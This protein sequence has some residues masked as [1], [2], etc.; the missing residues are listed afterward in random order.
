MTKQR[1]KVQVKKST[2]KII[3]APCYKST[4]PH[5]SHPPNICNNNTMDIKFLVQGRQSD[6]CGSVRNDDIFNLH[7]GSGADPSISIPCLLQ[8]TSHIYSFHPPKQLTRKKNPDMRFNSQQIVSYCLGLCT[9][10]AGLRQV[11][12]EPSPKG[13]SNKIK[14]LK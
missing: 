4:T 1:T 7:L 14:M 12:L 2:S 8:D 13:G 9:Q 5:L 11:D 3:T 6:K 10:N